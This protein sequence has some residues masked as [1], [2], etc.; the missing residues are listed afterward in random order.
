M[1]AN[2]SI[3]PAEFR[4]VQ[5]NASK[6]T[7]GFGRR[8]VMHNAPFSDNPFFEDLGKKGKVFNIDAYVISAKGEDSQAYTSAR[9]ALISAVEDVKGPGKFYH[10][11]MGSKTVV[12]VDCQVTYSNK[13]GRIERFRLTFAEY[14]TGPASTGSNSSSKASNSAVAYGGSS[15]GYKDV[16]NLDFNLFG[17]V[18][19][20]IFSDNYTIEKYPVK[21]SLLKSITKT[22]QGYIDDLNDFGKAVVTDKTE[23]SDFS[24]DFLDLSRLL[25]ETP[26]LVVGSA[27]EIFSS[28]KRISFGFT[29]MTEDPLARLKTAIAMYYKYL[30]VNS[31]NDQKYKAQKGSPIS[32]PLYQVTK[33]ELAFSTLILETSIKEMSDSIL[34]V[35]FSDRN[36]AT[37]YKNSINEVFSDMILVV[38]NSD[39]PLSYEYLIELQSNIN[40]YL[41]DQIER[42]PRVKII[43][44]KKVRPALVIAYNQ[45]EDSSKAEELIARNGIYNPNR[46]TVRKL[47]VLIDE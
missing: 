28:M 21:D 34:D 35:E 38:G 18:S 20:T 22:L 14:G 26:Q 17:G 46:V 45:Y 3:F 12:P 23:F 6:I 36:I 9:D 37:T 43:Q 30:G 32:S 40:V 27:S 42:L 10:P 2:E 16:L 11:T 5:F 29:L 15:E 39:S 47:E 44:N 33:S 25:N 41:G 1:P 7:T 4:G 24:K 8:G 13:E 19:G 31:E